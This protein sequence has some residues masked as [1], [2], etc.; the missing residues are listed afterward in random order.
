MVCDAL[1]PIL[2]HRAAFNMLLESNHPITHQAI[3]EET[4]AARKDSNSGPHC[5]NNSHKSPTDANQNVSVMM[6][7]GRPRSRLTTVVLPITC[8]KE[9]L[10]NKAAMCPHVS[11]GAIKGRAA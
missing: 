6:V 1:D 7:T 8:V 2:F 11:E 9:A 5:E 3:A 10:P 4:D